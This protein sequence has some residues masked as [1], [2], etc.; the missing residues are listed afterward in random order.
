MRLCT[1]VI[2]TV[3]LA[4]ASLATTRAACADDTPSWYQRKAEWNGYD[5]FHVKI[6]ERPAY[7]VVPQ[8]AAEGK[9]W[10][11]RARFPGYHAEMDVALL[12][13]GYHVAYVDVAGM[14][15]S[16]AAVAVGDAFY[17]FMTSR[18]GLSPKPCLEGVSRGGLFV[19]NWAAKHPDKVACIY[20]DTP[21]CDFKSWP[22]GMGGG[23]GSATTWQ[24][25]LKSYGMNEEEALAYRG[26]PIDHAEVIAK[27]QIPILHIVS[28]TDRVV[29]PKENT[30]LLKRRLKEHGHDMQ[31][32]SV[33]EGTAKSNGHHFDHPSV[34]RVVDFIRRNQ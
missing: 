9:P 4:G 17:E 29:P 27:A 20:C 11:W 33:A 14:F 16:P 18:R 34:D 30:Y 2:L 8:E 3:L 21:V 15:G 31:V 26:Q 5:Q 22:A 24:H 25:C 23:L 1:R 10:V 32:I 13:H 7:V 12:G 19:Y 28:E 6:A